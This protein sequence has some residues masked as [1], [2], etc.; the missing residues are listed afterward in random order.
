MVKHENVL[1]DWYCMPYYGYSWHS[2]GGLEHERE[3]TEGS[4][5]R[6]HGGQEF[7]GR[8][9]SSVSKDGSPDLR[10]DSPRFSK[11]SREEKKVTTNMLKIA[12]VVFLSGVGIWVAIGFR[13]NHLIEKRVLATETTVEN[14]LILTHEDGFKVVSATADHDGNI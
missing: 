7:A 4:K 13:H 14:A 3:T 6:L 12:L 9:R 2:V 11:V 10:A 1:V 5:A 8:A